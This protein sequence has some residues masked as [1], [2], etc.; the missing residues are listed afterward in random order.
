M[1]RANYIAANYSFKLYYV[2]K[3]EM[4]KTI[5]ITSPKY[6]DGDFKVL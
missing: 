3:K 5:A 6:K 2:V 4:E 1:A